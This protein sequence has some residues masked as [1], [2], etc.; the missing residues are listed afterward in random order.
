MKAYVIT[1]EQGK[2][3]AH[4]RFEESKAADTPTPGQPTAPEGH[5]LH[6]IEF[7]SELNTIKEPSELHNALEIHLKRHGSK[8]KK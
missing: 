8:K 4:I 1:N 7:P 6:E 2:V 3:V 5:T